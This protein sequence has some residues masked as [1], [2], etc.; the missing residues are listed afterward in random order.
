MI[1]SPC[2][3]VLAAALTAGI[4]SATR[5]SSSS[6]K[7]I[8]VAHLLSASGQGRCP[9]SRCT[10]GSR[11][12]GRVSPVVLHRWGEQLLWPCPDL[13]FSRIVA[14]ATFCPIH[15]PHCQTSPRTQLDKSQSCRW[16]CPS[17]SGFWTVGWRAA[18][19][20]SYVSTHA[21]CLRRY[22][23]RHVHFHL[24]VVVVGDRW[25]ADCLCWPSAHLKHVITHCCCR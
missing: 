22:C 5:L 1:T 12:G 16:C 20:Q 15:C 10:C 19:A 21:C 7:L 24:L 11:H 6:C 18:V 14:Y 2:A 9:S 25:Y 17:S 8:A 4:A 13:R 23:I 3:Q